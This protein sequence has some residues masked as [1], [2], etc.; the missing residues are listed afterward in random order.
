VEAQAGL[1]NP[2]V[3]PLRPSEA[4]WPE[5]LDTPEHWR[6]L[7]VQASPQEKLDAWLE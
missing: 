2:V 4:L 5:L 1:A 6:D 7:V 3:P